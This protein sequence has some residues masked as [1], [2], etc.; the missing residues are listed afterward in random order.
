MVAGTDHV[1]VQVRIQAV[2][3]NTLGLR[4]EQPTPIPLEAMEKANDTEWWYTIEAALGDPP[5]SWVQWTIAAEEGLLTSLGSPRQGA[6]NRGGPTR[7][8]GQATSRAQ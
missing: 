7:Y 5:D 6:V 2:V 3:A 1:G 4:M 8:T